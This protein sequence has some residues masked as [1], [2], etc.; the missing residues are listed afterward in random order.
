MRFPL[1]GRLGLLFVL[2]LLP[3]AVQAAEESRSCVAAA[4]VAEAEY[5]LP[6]GLLES[7]GRV[8]S[9][10]G[11]AREPWPWTVQADG[12]GTFHETAAEALA[13]VKRLRAEGRQLID[14]GCFQMDL[15]WHPDAFASLEQA[16]DPVANARAAARFLVALHAQTAD[17]SD[18]VGRYHSRNPLRSAVYRTH[19]L[20]TPSQEMRRV[21]RD[22]PNVVV[23]VASSARLRVSGGPKIVRAGLP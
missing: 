5:A 19:V 6:P 20:T 3:S 14:V 9:G 11:P 12:S 1:S 2:S 21:S 4:R 18:A 23:L 7:I 13:Q 16:F 8:E 10:R 15:F 22:D 17:W